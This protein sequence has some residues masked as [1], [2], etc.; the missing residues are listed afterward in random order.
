[1]PSR[2]DP[3]QEPYSADVQAIF[4][5][6]P[7]SWNPPFL[8]FTV[9]ARHPALLQRLIRGAPAYMPE[10]HLKLRQREVL[11]H[12]V[13]ARCGCEYE[14]GLRAHYF[15]TDANL[16]PEQLRATVHGDASSACWDAT[17]ALIIRLADE[18]H[19][20]STVSESLWRGLRGVF[21]DEAILEMLAL[22]GYYRTVGYL[23]NGLRLPREARGE[24]FPS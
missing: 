24:S 5:R 19:D 15:A 3:V 21:G 4:E 9:L 23:T 16:T 7:A 1:M 6:L 22:A 11:L 2:I 13:T 14:W 8:Y 17:D 18:L 12:R 20:T 10:L